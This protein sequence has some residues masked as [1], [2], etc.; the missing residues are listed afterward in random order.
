[1]HNP[2]Q[3]KDHGSFHLGNA[4]YQGSAVHP[5]RFP[6]DNGAEVAFAGRSNA[7]KSSALNT[8]CNRKALARI[9]RTP[10]RTQMLNFFAI[11]D[12]HRLVDLPGYGFAR[13][14]EQTR[15]KWKMFI[16]SYLS[17]RRSLKG[18]ILLMDVR[19]PMK[20]DD[21]QFLN[22][23][24]HHQIPVHV[25][26]TK[27]DKLRRGKLRET[28]RAVRADL[29]GSGTGAQLF[30]ARDRTGLD[31]ARRVIVTWLSAR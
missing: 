3:K 29:D 16:E 28:L 14:P 6:P 11:D 31:E 23:C 21:T 17:R 27:S 22:W 30:S 18:L 9:S 8:L 24:A 2:T 7:G 15:R 10:G 19:H 13:V 26:L 5:S 25:L 12:S 20:P 1:M 4:S